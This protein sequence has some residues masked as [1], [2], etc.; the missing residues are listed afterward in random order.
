V[1]A[2]SISRIGG[3]PCEPGDTLLHDH[4]NRGALVLGVVDRIGHRQLFPVL[5]AVSDEQCHQFMLDGL[6]IGLASAGR[7]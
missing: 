7:A 4:R 2:S 3:E 1:E 6:V 5:V